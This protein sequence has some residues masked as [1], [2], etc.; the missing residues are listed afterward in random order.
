MVYPVISACS[1]LARRTWRK[2][3]PL[4]PREAKN[5]IDRREAFE[6]DVMQFS[7]RGAMGAITAAGFWAWHE[8][9]MAA[10]LGGLSVGSA[11]G[12]LLGRASDS[13][14]D[15]L[16]KPG[17]F[18][19]DP[20]VRI[21]LPA[22]ARSVGGD[23]LG[24]LLGQAME[25]GGKLGLT[26][27]LVRRMNDA[28]GVAAGAAKPVFRTAISKLTLA[29]LPDLVTRGDGATQYLRKSSGDMLT[30]KLRPMVDGAMGRL[31]A[32][33]E[34]NRLTKN[35][36]V[37]DVVGLTRAALVKSVTEQAMNGIFGYIG[38]EEGKLRANPLDPVAGVL[39]GLFSR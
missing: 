16:A 13:A 28:A 34:L 33:A 31:G 5:A 30:G 35:P 1:L 18:Y 22:L 14:L 36:L 26:D 23:G 4:L 21:G 8:Q 7:R 19:G 10:G 9:A 25:A 24:G 37:A 38:V 17:A 6:G 20:A 32:V 2:N 3:E 11:L 15:Q 27:G 39:K 12:G 29:D